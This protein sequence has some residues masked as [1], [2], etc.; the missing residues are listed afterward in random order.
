MA[1]VM[2]GASTPGVAA[3]SHRGPTMSRRR[4]EIGLAYLLLAPA[5]VLVFGVLVYPLGWQVWTSLT[6]WF[7]GNTV[8]RFVGVANYAALLRD[9][10]FWRAAVNTV[11]YIAITTVL[12]LAVGIG[13][14]VLLA[15]PFPG[16]A[17]AFVAAFL[18]WA[19]PAGP[20]E[21]GWFWFLMPPVHASY[22]EFMARLH[23]AVDDALGVGTWGFLS[24][25][26]LNVWRGGSFVGI[27]LLAAR[28]G[29]P[30]QLFEYA[31]LEARNAW[32]M[33]WRVTVP[34]MR[35]FL[36]LAAFLSLTSAVADLSNIWMQSGLR[37]V[38]PIVWTQAMHLALNGGRWALA[39][40]ETL[41]VLPVLLAVLL[42][43]FRLFEPLE[44][45]PS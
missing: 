45:D 39:S 41:A 37:E 26:L 36:A 13:I 3:R 18:P 43:C 12:K 42:L 6:D 11:G 34:I 20:A 8:V 21:M 9:A 1:Q 40:A 4:R 30:D 16:R 25:I 17:L 14:A 23:F 22:G 5:L 33:F 10:D 35:P 29:I 27:F 38:Y 19:Y 15:R 24:V 44:E 7:A 32:Q 28:N 2:L 31:A